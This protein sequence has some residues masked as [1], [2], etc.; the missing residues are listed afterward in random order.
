MVMGALTEACFYVYVA[1]AVADADDP[2]ATRQEVRARMQK[3]LE[4]LARTP[5]EDWRRAQ[6]EP[7]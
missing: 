5:P 2:R 6:P 7:G 1:D 4:G 3:L